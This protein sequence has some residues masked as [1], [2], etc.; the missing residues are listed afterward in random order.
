MHYVRFGERTVASKSLN[1]RFFDC[2]AAGGLITWQTFDDSEARRGWLARITHG[3]PMPVDPDAGVFF[4]INETNGR[5]RKA[6]DI[7]AVRTWCIDI[8]G[9]QPL[10]IEWHL[11]PSAIV[12]TRNGW[13]VYWFALEGA[14]TQTFARIQK[15]LIQRYSSDAAVCDLPRVMRAPGSIHRKGEPFPIE[16]VELH[17]ERRYAESEMPLLAKPDR[18][19]HRPRVRST[20]T[21]VD[22]LA[23]WEGLPHRSAEHRK[24]T[25][26]TMFRALCLFARACADAGETPSV[27]A[28]RPWSEGRGWDDVE[29]ADTLDRISRQYVQAPAATEPTVQPTEIWEQ[30]SFDDISQARAFLSSLRPLQ[31]EALLLRA[32]MGLGKTELAGAL[33]RTH[34]RC[35]AVA[36]LRALVSDLA[37]RFD[38]REDSDDDGRCVTTAASAR[39]F[40]THDRDFV[41]FDEFPSTLSQL[42]SDFF[43]RDDADSKLAALETALRSPASK[44]IASADLR[45]EHVEFVRS[46]G[47]PV[48]CVSV[49]VRG[50]LARTIVK[51]RG[52]IEHVRR[53][54]LLA[55]SRGERVAI[56]ATS[57]KECEAMASLARLVRPSAKVV[58]LHS[59]SDSTRGECDV[60]VANTVIAEGVNI[61][62]TF[63]SLYV[64][65]DFRDVR[66]G[67]VAQ[68][69]G[70]FRSLTRSEVLY[71]CPAW[72]TGRKVARDMRE[73][74]EHA[75]KQVYEQIGFL[76]SACSDSLV[77]I[78]Q[79]TEDEIVLSLIHI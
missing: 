42:G 61:T 51:A 18:A 34:R 1:E 20:A 59:Q 76:P 4:C 43:S 14:S 3:G 46:Q 69:I 65:H 58:V 54:A 11:P 13:H 75:R 17:P 48:R 67:T 16:V 63:D 71:G 31:G 19:A 64:I 41:F 56:F 7:V 39:K 72:R 40:R 79:S 74:L 21:I 62:D 55:V 32:P 12:R 44:L 49:S 28:L 27:D 66:V 30:H 26:A 23:T 50:V 53:E 10:P 25:G 45:D 15:A 73:W 37:R 22:S 36:P 2:I 8:D 35:L 77:A 78:M 57:I 5:G 60:L 47:C 24:V 68:G 52:G 70:R 9:G 33:W 38:A 6:T 29:L